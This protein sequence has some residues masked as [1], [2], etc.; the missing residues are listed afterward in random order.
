MRST[1]RGTPNKITVAVVLNG[2]V[3]VGV[4]L[5]SI[6][7]SLLWG[8][9]GYEHFG[10]EG[11]GVTEI[12]EGCGDALGKGLGYNV[13]VKIDLE[14][15]NAAGRQISHTGSGGTVDLGRAA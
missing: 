11:I 2:P 15:T 6:V 5:K 10:L 1:S 14:S 4:K 8:E 9:S 13:R 12:S 3:W 7:H